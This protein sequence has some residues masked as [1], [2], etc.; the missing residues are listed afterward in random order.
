ME[1]GSVPKGKGK[2]V[3]IILGFVGAR[4]NWSGSESDAPGAVAGFDGRDYFIRCG[5]DYGYVVR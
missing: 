2:Q 5:I 3:Y 1:N 4:I